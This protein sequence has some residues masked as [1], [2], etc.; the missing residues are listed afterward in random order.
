VRQ[1]QQPIQLTQTLNNFIFTIN[2]IHVK[3]ANFIN[4]TLCRNIAFAIELKLKVLSMK[5]KCKNRYFNWKKHIF[6][7]GIV[8][9]W[10]E[11]RRKGK[12]ININRTSNRRRLKLHCYFPSIY[13]QKAL[14]YFIYNLLMN[15]DLYLRWVVFGENVWRIE[16]STWFSL[17]IRSTVDL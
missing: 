3:S 8:C 2:A 4:F 7:F 15:L 1:R 6:V 17:D 9:H 12:T 5:V 14:Y 13:L 10:R 16:I 11:Y